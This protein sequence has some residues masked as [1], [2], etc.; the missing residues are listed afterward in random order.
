MISGHLVL[1]LEKYFVVLYFSNKSCGNSNAV[2]RDTYP[3]YRGHALRLPLSSSY[4]V[5]LGNHLYIKE[6][7]ELVLGS[8]TSCTMIN[9]VHYLVVVY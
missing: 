5:D 2:S 1:G 4:C 6:W 3:S 7:C 9:I 8:I